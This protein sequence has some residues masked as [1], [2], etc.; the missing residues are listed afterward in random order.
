[1]IFGDDIACD[2]ETG[3]PATFELVSE[4]TALVQALVRRF[5]TARG[6]LVDDP[7]Y[8]LDLTIW[9]G[10]RTDSA[11]LFA[12][13]QALQAEA[14]KEARVRSARARVTA[15]RGTSTL[16]FTLALET[17]AG[18]FRLTIQASQASVDLLS[19]EPHP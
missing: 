1:M 4:R 11:Q 2:P 10:Q 16:T 3:I 9:I 14:R 15:D 17:A 12:W 8:G 19:V 18:P 5:Q 6:S 7:D 13:Q